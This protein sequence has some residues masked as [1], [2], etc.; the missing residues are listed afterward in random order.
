M[1]DPRLSFDFESRSTVPFGRAKGAVTAYQYSRHPD[2]SIWCMSWAIG[3]SEVK[4]WDPMK[5]EPFPDDVV[6][7]LQQRIV[8]QAWNAGFEWNIWNHILVPRWGLPKLPI[9]QM[10]CTAARA[11]V[12]ALPRS[13]EGAGAA[14][15]LEIQ[16]DDEGARLMMRMAKPRKPRK[17]EDPDGI[18]WWDDEERRA[19]LGAY[20][21]RDTEVERELGKIVR[22]LSKAERQVWLMDH[23]TNMLG[24]EVDVEFARKAQAVMA[25]VEDKYRQELIRLTNGAVSAPTEVGNLREWL[26]E[27]GVETDSVDK[28]SVIRMLEDP[29]VPDEVKQVLTVRQEAGKSSV[30]KY[31][32]FE[33][34]TSGDGR[35]RENFLYHGANTGRLAG[36]GAQLQNLPSRG[37]L[38]WR[39]ADE[40]FNLI[41]ETED[42][43]WAADRVELFYGEVPTALSS[44]LRGTI[45]ASEGNALFVA[46]Y[47]NIEGRIA[48]WL[49]SEQ[50]KL[51]AFR[52][53]DAG[54]GPDLYKVTA[55]GI[56]GKTPEAVDGTERNVIGKVPELA[57]G[58]GGGVG[59]FQSMAKNFGVNMADYWEIIQKAL[60]AQFI[61]K[62]HDNWGTFGKRSGLDHTEW[63]ASEAVKLGWRARHKGIVRCWYDAEETAKQALRQPGKWFSFAGGKCAHGAAEYGGVMFLISRLPSGRRTYRAQARLRPVTKFGRQSEEVRFM[64]VDSVTRQWVSMGTYGGDLFQTCLAADTLVLTDQGW[65]PIQNITRQ[66]TIWDGENWTLSDGAVCNGD[67][68]TLNLSGVRM[69]PEH[70]VLTDEGWKEASSCAGH[71]RA[72]SRIPDCFGVRGFGWEEIPLVGG[73]RVR[74]EEDVPSV[75]PDEGCEEG[76]R[77]VLRLS[78]VGDNLQTSQTPREIEASDV[79]RMG[80]HESPVQQSEEPQ[81]RQLRR[82]G[83]SGVQ[84]LA[85]GLCKFSEGHGAN[86]LAGS[87][88]GAEGRERGLHAREL[89][90]GD[91]GAAGTEQEGEHPSAEGLRPRDSE[92][93][94]DFPEHAVL[95]AETRLAFGAVGGTTGDNEAVYDIVN[96]GPRNRFVVRDGNG[97]PMIVHNCVQAIARDVMIHGWANVE[98]L[99]FDVVLS[100]HD[101]V[102]AEASEDRELAEFEAA[103]IDLPE[104]ATGL[105]ISAEGYKSK[106]Y[107]KD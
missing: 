45:R 24:V 90:L 82:A 91:M 94:R 69:T 5:D 79:P 74:G 16:K 35:M 41:L 84:E 77:H 87:D 68:G 3:D 13:L 23:K 22:P 93:D 50:W 29:L 30:A 57:L 33:Q 53:Y 47:S 99:G 103:M 64:G 83:H 25:T 54:E 67:K 70:L 96:C 38:S 6:H 86:V 8:F 27:Q 95:S 32:R 40:V 37:G 15:G 43:A 100:V 2:T 14:L 48:A 72:E 51:D 21:I 46:D 26:A 60:D 101:E 98:A 56:L 20:C 1:S 18:F 39:E 97:Q 65:K 42:P 105:P 12:M 81:L 9:E 63:V 89:H 85:R 71:N 19:R 44:C 10:D 88:L 62:A 75:R 102:G 58:F 28:A 34:L 78:P 61:Q 107:R 73:M 92:T 104:W 66:D 76:P 31:V 4:L 17:N 59:A 49:G 11:A 106:R 55:G 7:A 52:A 36:R 80:I